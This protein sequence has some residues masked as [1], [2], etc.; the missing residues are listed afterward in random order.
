MK[1]A[2]LFLHEQIDIN[3]EKKTTNQYEKYLANIVDVDVSSL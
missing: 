3:P 1:M 2:Q